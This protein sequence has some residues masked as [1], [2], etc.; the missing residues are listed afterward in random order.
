MLGCSRVSRA[1]A[2]LKHSGS[3]ARL[4]DFIVKYQYFNMKSRNTA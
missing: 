2:T 3:I 4:D 1:R